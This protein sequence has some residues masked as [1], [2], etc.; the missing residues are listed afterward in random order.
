MIVKIIEIRLKDTRNSNSFPTRTTNRRDDLAHRKHDPTKLHQLLAQ[1]VNPKLHLLGIDGVVEELVLYVFNHVVEMLNGIEMAVNKDIE[2]SVDDTH[3]PIRDE[4]RVRVEAVEYLR[5]LWQL[6]ALPAHGAEPDHARRG[7]PPAE[8][9]TRDPGPRLRPDVMGS[10]DGLAQAA[11]H[12]ESR[13]LRAVTTVTENDVSYAVRGDRGATRYDD[14]VGVGMYRIDLHPST[15]GD[16]YIDVASTPFEIPLG[17]LLPQRV[18]NLLAANKNIGTTHITNGCYRLHPVEWNVGEAA[19]H[20]AAHCL[21][22]GRTPHAVQSKADLLADYQ[23]ELVRAGV[24]LRWPAEAH[25][26]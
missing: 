17:A 11:Y 23:D 22:T 25:P 1:P 26:Y 2:N 13:R 18:T 15:G 24:E 8:R 3:R 19:G 20:L 4:V 10:P 5:A 16:T 21:A 6:V 7:P 14:S 12:R 9:G